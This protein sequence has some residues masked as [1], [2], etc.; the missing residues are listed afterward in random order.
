MT[1]EAQL[2]AAREA[3][4]E[5][6]DSDVRPTRPRPSVQSEVRFADVRMNTFH[7]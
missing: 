7:Q 3:P 5:A 6:K 2:K 1:M 4:I